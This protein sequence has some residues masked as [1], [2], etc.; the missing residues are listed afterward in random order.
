MYASAKVSTMGKLEQ[1]ESAIKAL[2]AAELER[3]RRWFAEFD[4]AQ[5]DRQLERDVAAG[6]LD[7]LAERALA[8]HSAGRTTPL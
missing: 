6:R 5:W 4:A 3:F 8:E 2:S 7:K 1:I